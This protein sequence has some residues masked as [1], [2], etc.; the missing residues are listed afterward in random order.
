M[1]LQVEYWDM[2]L[3]LKQWKCGYIRPTEKPTVS[4][5]VREGHMRRASWWGRTWMFWVPSLVP[6]LYILFVSYSSHSFWETACVFNYKNKV[7]LIKSIEKKVNHIQ[8][9][10]PKLKAAKCLC[11]CSLQPHLKQN[12]PLS[13]KKACLLVWGV[14]SLGF[15]GHIRLCC[16]TSR[17]LCWKPLY[18]NVCPLSPFRFINHCCIP[19]YSG[20][21][22]SYRL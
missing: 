15:P 6:F 14:F 12:C 10:Q 7:L 20:G 8:F 4:Q 13:G 18:R 19:F 1:S 11:I 16:L 5:T 21:F 22:C 17:N 2:V 9:Y 3:T